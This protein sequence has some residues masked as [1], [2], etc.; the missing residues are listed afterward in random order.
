LGALRA[1]PHHWRDGT[2]KETSRVRNERREGDFS[3]R[4]WVAAV[5]VL[6]AV[7]VAAVLALWAAYLLLG[8]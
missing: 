2:M 1:I 5:S 4:D 3:A 7:L 6:G 8:G